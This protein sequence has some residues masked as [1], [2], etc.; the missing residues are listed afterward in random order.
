MA[1]LRRKCGS[2]HCGVARR[3]LE[4][5]AL[6]L[7]PHCRDSKRLRYKCMRQVD[8][9]LSFFFV[10][11]VDTRARISALEQLEIRARRPN[12]NVPCNGHSK[13]QSCSSGGPP[14]RQPPKHCRRQLS[15]QGPFAHVKLPSAACAPAP[16][17]AWPSDFA[18]LN[19]FLLRLRL[20]KH[21]LFGPIDLYAPCHSRLLATWCGSKHAVVDWKVMESKWGTRCGP[22]ALVPAIGL[23]QGKGRKAQATRRVNDA[24]RSRALP[25]VSGLS[26]KVPSA[27]LLPT[28]KQSVRSAIANCSLGWNDHERV[29]AMSRVRFVV[30]SPSKFRDQ[31]NA[32]K[33]SKEL[34]SKR[35]D[36]A[37]SLGVLDGLR[38]VEKVWDVPVRLSSSDASRAVEG[39]VASCCSKLGLCV[40]DVAAATSCGV[41]VLNSC[42]VCIQESRRQLATL[43]E[44]ESYT[45]DMRPCPDQAVV[46]GDK[47][48]K[49]MW[50]LPVW[51]Y[52]HLLWHFALVAKTWHVSCLSVQVANEWCLTVLHCLLTDRMKKFI[53]FRRYR[54]VLPYTYGTFKAKCFR[55]GLHT[56]QRAGHS[57]MR[58]IVSF[59]GWP[60]RRRWRFVHKALE[61]LVRSFVMSDEVWGLKDVCKVMDSRMST[62]CAHTCRSFTCGRCGKNKPPV[63]AFSA[64]A[65]QFYETVSPSVAV[66]MTMQLARRVVSATGKNTVTVLRGRRRHAYLG[67]SVYQQGATSYCFLI[68]DLVLAFAACMFMGLCRVGDA[69][70]RM[71]GLPIGGVLSKVAASIV[72]GCEE[73]AWLHDVVLRKRLGFAATTLLWDREVARAR[74]VDDV[75]WISGVYCQQCLHLALDT[76]Y[77]VKFD[78]AS[79]GPVVNW[80]DVSLDVNSLQ[81]SMIQKP[82]VFPPYWAAPSGFL[83][84]FFSG[85]FHRWYEVPLD[86][87]AWLE[88]VLHV[89][90]SLYHHAWPASIVRAAFFQARHIL[91]PR[92]QRMFLKGF[93]GIWLLPEANHRE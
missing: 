75:L 21:G 93:R 79:D 70:F 59:A 91:M 32:P 60:S 69:C 74:Y 67:G 61:T 80:L 72:L 62:A 73:E 25:P 1:G 90:H 40:S 19:I 52:Q 50:L 20:V 92:H 12:A 24:L 85:R 58:K 68:F 86:D 66:H 88:A 71:E 53:C 33:V 44:Y 54:C 37:S 28:V 30:A 63:V 23:V 51:L 82:W 83:R 10:C 81:W 46:P 26:C 27:C 34:Q 76:M 77:T 39:C 29:W 9:G 15:V 49:Y 22:A 5:G 11:R 16:S 2:V 31:F 89:L 84:S 57:C 4:H 56:C 87:V 7:R 41:R 18:S 55:D 65:G 47:A 38:R 36:A 8:F 14:R 6:L 42:P 35:I 45:A 13:R 17:H 43:V 64:D 48:K 3:W 78:I